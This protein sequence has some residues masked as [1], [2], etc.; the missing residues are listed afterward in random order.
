[1]PHACV[2]GH[3]KTTRFGLKQE[4]ILLYIMDVLFKP[5]FQRVIVDHG[6][7]QVSGWQPQQGSADEIIK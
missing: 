2:Q 3:K 5:L 6:L 4:T 7:D 1:M